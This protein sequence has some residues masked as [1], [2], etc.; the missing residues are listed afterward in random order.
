VRVVSRRPCVHPDN[1]WSLHGLYQCLLRAGK[2]AEAS[3][4][5]Y[6]CVLIE[7]SSTVVC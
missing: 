2:A 4:L 1:V 6:V 3:V 5:K 7:H